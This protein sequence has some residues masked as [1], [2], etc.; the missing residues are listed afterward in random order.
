MAI[1]KKPAAVDVTHPQYGGVILFN[2]GGP[3]ASGVDFIRRYGGSFDRIFNTGDKHYDLLGWDPRGSGDTTPSINGLANLV[4]HDYDQK[5]LDLMDSAEH[6]EG[7]NRFYD[8]KGIY[9]KF[10]SDSLL[11][12]GEDQPVQ[13]IGTANVVRD[14]VEIIEKHGK[15][16]EAAAEKVMALRKLAGWRPSQ[17]QI[18]TIRQRVA[19]RKDSEMLQ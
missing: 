19:Y 7:F 3:A 6:E 16:R 10:V 18:Q 2:P 4:R 15:W 13:F 9:G 8:M 1:I 12:N 11:V 5:L 17:T 14:M